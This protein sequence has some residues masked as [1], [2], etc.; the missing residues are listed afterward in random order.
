MRFLK[1]SFVLFFTLLAAQANAGQPGVYA[2]VMVG[3]SI[4]SDSDV[5]EVGGPGVA[6]L[7]TD[8]GVGFGG[9]GG[10]DFG[11]NIRAELELSYRYNSLDRWIE[12]GTTTGVNGHASSFA[13][14]ANGF[15]DFDMGQFVPYVGGGVGFA[16]IG[17]E[18]DTG[19]PNLADDS[20]TVFAWQIAGGVGY[21][22]TPKFIISLDYRLFATTDAELL[23]NGTVVEAEY[24]THNLML[25][26][27]YKF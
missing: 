8:V 26:G 17:L 18:L 24:F 21:K 7:E 10:Y 5:E 2:G 1:I 4:L 22:L 19:G 6:I 20:D 27:R 12:G 25:G 14:M 9:V 3:M 11:N 15:Y 13:V 23:V 16:V